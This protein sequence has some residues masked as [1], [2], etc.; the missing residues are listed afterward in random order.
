MG[1]VAVS[2]YGERPEDLIKEVNRQEK[3]VAIL[4]V[5]V[6]PGIESIV[7]DLNPDKVYQS[8]NFVITPE[9]EI[10]KGREEKRNSSPI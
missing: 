8:T 2:N 3:S 9:G 6:D 1:A 5:Q 4:G 7:K 10:Y